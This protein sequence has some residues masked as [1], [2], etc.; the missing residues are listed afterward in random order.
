M[1]G[2]ARRD[3]ANWLHGRIE[4][5][6]VSEFSLD[7][8]FRSALG[9]A[10]EIVLQT[11]MN[12]TSSFPEDS[13]FEVR[14]KEFVAAKYSKLTIFGLD[15]SDRSQAEWPLDAAYLSLE[16]TSSEKPTEVFSGADRPMNNHAAHQPA[17]RALAGHH[18]VLLRGVAGS[19]KTTLIQWLAVSAAKQKLGDHLKHLRDR[20]PFVLPLRTII[21]QSELPLPGAFLSAIRS[22]LAGSQPAGWTDRILGDGRG[23]LLIDGIDEISNADRER[24]RLWLR[25]LMLSFPHNLWL[26]TSRPSAVSDS[27]LTADD[28]VELS[29]APM[30]RED[31]TAFVNRWHSAA[32]T[33]CRSAEEEERIRA[34]EASLL[35]SMWTKQDLGRLATNPLMCGLICALHRDRRGYLPP[36]RKQL[37]DAAL[38]MLLARRDRERDLE[39]RLAEEPQIQLLQ[40]LAYWLI[41]NGQVE[42][43][44]S[45]AVDLIS[46]ALPAMPA[47]Q[48]VGTAEEIYDLL[49]LRSGMLREPMKG[50]MDFIHRT[51]QDYLGAKAAIEARDFDL[52][53]KNAHHDQWEDV[54]RMAVAHA[55]PVERSRLLKKLITRGDRTKTHRTR[56]HLLAMAC[57][58]HAIELDPDVRSAVE[59][60]A[61]ALIPPQDHDEAVALAGAG[62][63]VLELLP[64]P[65]GLSD[66]QAAS[67]VTTASLL[68]S[69]AALAVLVKYRDHPAVPQIHETL[70]R[71]WSLFD[72]E[73]YGREVIAHLPVDN[74]YWVDSVDHVRFLGSLGNRHR[75]ISRGNISTVE[76]E[77]SIDSKITLLGLHA[78]EALQSLDFLHRMQDLDTLYLFSCNRIS[79]LTPLSTLPLLNRLSINRMEGLGWLQGLSGLQNLVELDIMQPVTSGTLESLP[80][81]GKLEELALSG[82]ALESTELRDL[83]LCQSLQSLTLVA[84]KRAQKL[85]V[86]W[87][88][89]H[90]K[91]VSRLEQLEQLSVDSH[92][93]RGILKT[94]PLP[95]ITKLTLPIGSS[96]LLDLETAEALSAV[97][98]NLGEITTYLQGEVF[99]EMRNLWPGI[100]VIT[101]SDDFSE[102]E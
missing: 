75:L 5:T 39:V 74:V 56:L 34:Y 8:G 9:P 35:K 12:V 47:V 6:P 16:A 73:H 20:V 28:F 27:W 98:P 89:S 38:S 1:L 48:T 99:E 54:I 37:Y 33:G 3:P 61:A 68:V 71:N 29:L 62:A 59:A 53:V 4:A 44:R 17:D 69:D 95:G 67:V 101:H 18:R 43:D 7:P 78:N 72:T 26:V 91:E 55:Y 77:N 85:G 76:L 40:K 21:R 100:K 83:H 90:W 57:L 32:L 80:K 11:S 60:R 66:I 31:I 25:E 41:R 24:V 84:G 30:R 13:L 97:L 46:A 58:E 42:M 36:G 45:D 81:I 10:A 86:A 79:D 92:V 102:I 52:M 87:E 15:F 50:T 49:L 65:D 51:F 14:Y 22:P 63:M 94:P 70:T 23:L 82:G 19:G 96:D 93:L 88:R 64:G 2:V